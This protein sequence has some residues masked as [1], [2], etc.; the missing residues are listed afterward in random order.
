MWKNTRRARGFTAKQITPTPR[1]CEEFS[2]YSPEAGPPQPGK[3]S[4]TPAG[5]R[6]DTGQVRVFGQGSVMNIQRTCSCRHAL[7]TIPPTHLCRG[8]ASAQREVSYENSVWHYHEDQPQ[9]RCPSCRKE[10]VQA[11]SCVLRPYSTR[12][13]QTDHFWTPPSS[14]LPRFC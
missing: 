2:E 11:G 4:P 9:T 12:C 1:R 7:T 10:V 8:K 13:V 14:R 3:I 5:L 6:I